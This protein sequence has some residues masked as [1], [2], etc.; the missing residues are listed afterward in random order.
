MPTPLILLLRLEGPLQAWGLR[1]RWDVRDSH[2]EPT[3]SAVI[4]LLAAS[5]GYERGD[6]RIETELDAELTMGVRVEQAG[7]PMRDFHTVTGDHRTANDAWRQPGGGSVKSPPSESTT[8]VSPRTYLQD[9][10]FLVVVAGPEELLRRCGDA[11]QSPRWSTYLGR[12]SCPPVRPVYEALSD[13]YE[14][15]EDALRRHPWSCEWMHA[16]G[17]WPTGRLR[18]T[19]EDPDGDAQRPDAVRINASRM[20]GTRAVRVFTIDPPGPEATPCT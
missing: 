12:R 8:I 2:D 13:A 18:C 10:A 17:Q 20:Y 7:V 14:A 11:L 4:G 5:L 15:L 16:C 3:K 6:R 1:A 9:A 19:V